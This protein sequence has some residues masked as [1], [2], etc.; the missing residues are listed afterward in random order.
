MYAFLVIVTIILPN[1]RHVFRVFSP[2]Q[3]AE[4]VCKNKSAAMA[5]ISAAYIKQHMPFAVVQ[6]EATCTKLETRVT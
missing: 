5:E 4:P 1:Q 2:D 3:F 6:T